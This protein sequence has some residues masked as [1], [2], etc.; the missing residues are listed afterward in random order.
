VADAF[1]ALCTAIL[2]AE[3]GSRPL[4]TP[5][6]TWQERLLKDWEGVICVPTITTSDSV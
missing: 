4:H 2:H 6:P 1:V 5:D 3:N